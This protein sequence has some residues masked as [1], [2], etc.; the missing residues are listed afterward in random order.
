MG[1]RKLERLFVRFRKEGDAAAMA[2]VFDRAGPELLELAV[3]LVRDP[4]EA[5]DVVQSTFLAAIERAWSFDPR[6]RL[7]P[8][9]VGIL[10][11]QAGLARRRA[12]REVEPDR[13]HEREVPD[14]ARQ[15][16]AQELSRELEG[17]LESLPVKYRE[18][19]SP[20]LTH[21]MRP[22]DI[23]RQLRRAPGTVRMQMHRGLE[24]LRRALPAGFAATGVLC[25]TQS[26]GWAAVRD[27]VVA[28]AREF[29]SSGKAA[30]GAAAG[31]G[32]VTYVKLALVG[33]LAATVAGVAWM[34]ASQPSSASP[35]AEAHATRAPWPESL[36]STTLSAPAVDTRRE[37]TTAVA[38]VAQPTPA[39]VLRGNVLGLREDELEATELRVSAI[40]RFAWPEDLVVRGTPERDGSFE[41]DVTP[42]FEDVRPARPREELLLRVDHPDHAPGEARIRL[43]TAVEGR[44]EPLYEADVRLEDAAR[45]EGRVLDEHGR[46]REDA[47]VAA[48]R[49]EGDVPHGPPLDAQD[50]GRSFAL[51]LARPGRY[52]VVA[53]VPGQRPGTALV[54]VSVGHTLSIGA[55]GLPA[56]QWIEGRAPY[57]GGGARVQAEI[58]APGPRSTVDGQELVWHAGAFERARVGA[59]TEADGSFTLSGLAPAFHHL[60]ATPSVSPGA[61]SRAPRSRA[62]APAHGLEL[63]VFG[64]HVEL[65]FVPELR[66]GLEARLL[67]RQVGRTTRSVLEPAR[68][69]DVEPGVAAQI[70]IEV[71][72]YHPAAVELPVLEPG[73]LVHELVALV[74]DS[75]LG[76]VIFDWVDAREVSVTPE[77][78]TFVFEPLG[79]GATANRALVRHVRPSRGTF[80]VSG[81]PSGSWSVTAHAGG[82]YRHYLELS[83]EARVRV[84]VRPGGETRVRVR[85]QPGARL[86]LSAMD[87]AGKLVR[88]E[89]RVLDAGGRAL[90]VR[91]LGARAEGRTNRTGVLDGFAASDVYPN[92]A[93][94]EYRVELSAEGFEPRSVYV[95]LAAGDYTELPVRLEPLAL[96]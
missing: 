11:R 25:V 18:I 41:L 4:A 5:E 14:P 20:Y 40:A 26:R 80:R 56:G 8:W 57:A 49:V 62:H 78:A 50:C 73:D 65:T 15:A 94:G 24:L 70:T 95:R 90:D 7:M 22:V 92:L 82:A 85:R 19:L 16:Q 6:L 39:Y 21:G 1:D 33:A 48:F 69:I 89:C 67:V 30:T 2:E 44:Y 71:E 64:A 66:A 72:G 45:I 34:N 51:R 75:D 79:S 68:G 3:H 47:R 54:D 32:A 60:H 31:T 28:R 87:A 17:A 36:S 58:D 29:S 46:P 88:A 52:A 43:A 10:T 9:L 83:S 35:I 96:R 37:L 61:E 84:D 86:R 38:T 77:K 91:F 13:L 23:A 93:P 63:P 12:R 42:L 53:L 59:D 55:L 74:A 81:I 76:A 27:Q